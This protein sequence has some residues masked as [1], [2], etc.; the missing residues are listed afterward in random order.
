TLSDTPRPRRSTTMARTRWTCCAAW[1]KPR[2]RR[3]CSG[4]APGPRATSGSRP[5]TRRPAAPPTWSRRC[6]RCASSERPRRCSR[7]RR[8]LGP[9][10]CACA[11]RWTASNRTG[12]GREVLPTAAPKSYWKTQ[13]STGEGSGPERPLSCPKTPLYEPRWRPATRRWT[14]ASFACAVRSW[15]PPP[16]SCAG[17]ARAASRELER[18]EAGAKSRPRLPSKLLPWRPEEGEKRRRRRSSGRRSTLS[19]AAKLGRRRGLHELPRRRA[20]RSLL[21]APRPHP[22]RPCWGRIRIR[23]WSACGSSCSAPF[24]TS[25]PPRL[26]ASSSRRSWTTPLTW[27]AGARPRPR[28]QR[29]WS[30]LSRPPRH[31]WPRCA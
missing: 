18:R 9:R 22:P 11:P 10:A 19:R 23:R 25:I 29:S 5:W 16:P 27:W 6:L 15:R 8:P 24:W 3:R 17:R 20:P 13:A 30:P 1:R 28:W 7:E 31:A 14:A 21:P 4:P 12:P 26:T 2:R